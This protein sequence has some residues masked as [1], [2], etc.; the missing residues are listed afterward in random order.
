[1]GSP[2]AGATEPAPGA[3]P[4]SSETPLTP[5]QLTPQRMQSIGVKLGTVEM[6]NVSNAIRVTGNVDVDERRLANV[7]L[8]FPGWIHKVFVD[9]TYALVV[10]GQPLLTIY[11]PDLVT[12]QQEYLLTRKNQQQTGRR[13]YDGGAC[14]ANT[15][16]SAGQE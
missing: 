16:V 2:S 5:V 9:A 6:K 15:I 13:P 4:G 14:G 7:Q 10:K 11:S 8:R 1:M 12:T 3:A